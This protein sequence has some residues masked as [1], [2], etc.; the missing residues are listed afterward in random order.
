[1]TNRIETVYRYFEPKTAVTPD[2]RR[3]A[4]FIVAFSLMGA[5]FGSMFGGFYTLIGHYWG[6]GIIAVCCVLFAMVP[7]LLRQGVSSG[8]AGNHYCLILLSGFFCLCW[9]EGGMNGHALAWLVIVP[10]CALLLTSRRGAYC[11]T[12]LSFLAALVTTGVEAFGISPPFRYPMEWHV[13]VSVMGYS[14]LVLF[15]FALGMVFETGRKTAHDQ[16][17]ATLKELGAANDWLKRLNEEKSEFLGIAAHDLRSPLTVVMGCADMIQYDEMPRERVVKAASS[18]LREAKRMRTLISDL[19]DLNAIEEGKMNVSINPVVIG[20]AA[21]AMCEGHLTGAARKGITLRVEIAPT[22]VAMA[23]EKAL[24]QVLDNLL[25]NAVKFTKPGGEVGFASWSDEK[26]TWIKIRDTGPGLSPEDKAKLFGRFAKLSARPTGG[27]SS[28]GL[29]LSIVKKL[30]DAMQG[31]IE[32]ES[33]L[34]KGTAFILRFAK[35]AAPVK[36]AE[37]IAEALAGLEVNAR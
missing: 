20:E 36:E 17:E 6:G 14:A 3:R 23:D 33:E 13:A 32:C 28:H 18:I 31:T 10:L 19:L 8:R 29:G 4:R 27:E 30:V 7:Y 12:G 35:G 24:L 2:N 34:G 5:I 15:L 21:E 22:A 25:S 37:E 16:M 11:W 26:F 1:M 9:V